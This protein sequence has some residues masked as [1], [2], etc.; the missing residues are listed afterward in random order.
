VDV[1]AAV[2]FGRLEN[3]GGTLY[4]I[5]GQVAAATAQTAV[6]Y[7]TPN[8]SGVPAAW[9]TAS[10]VLPAARSQL[11]TA[12]YNG[13]IYATG[14]FSGA[15]ATPQTSVYYSPDLSAGGNIGSAWTTNGT[16]FQLARSGHKTVAYGNNLYVLGGF[17]GTNYLLDVQFA[18][19]NANGSVGT[20]VYAAS[21]PQLARQGDA[22]AS[23]GFMYVFGGRSAASTCTANTYVVPINADGSFGVWSQTSVGYSGTRWGVAAA[24]D[25]GRAYLLGGIC[26]TT[27]TGANRAVYGTLQMQPQLANYSLLIDTD[28]DVFP[29]KYLINGLDNGIGAAW[30]L[31]YISSTNAANSWGQSTNAGKVILGTPGTYTPKDGAGANTNFSRYHMLFLTIDDQAAFGFPEDITRGPN[32]YDV[33]LQFSSNPGKRLRNGKT[34]TG[35]VQQPLDTP[36]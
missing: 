31:K 24:Y 2:A 6:Y 5:G 23:N 13:R 28:T 36:F 14:G 19:I 16:S 20:W 4:Y 7:S 22:F 26:G 30:F 11:S 33:T 29:S 9:S 27:L 15:N 8:G 3:V 1:P 34:F 12:V 18:P 32:I 35:G 17:D 25:R 10:N 21:L